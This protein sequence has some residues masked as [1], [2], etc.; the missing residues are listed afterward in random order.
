MLDKTAKASTTE[1]EDGKWKELHMTFLS[2]NGMRWG[3][4][5][6]LP[7]M[8]DSAWWPVLTSRE[9]ESPGIRSA[10]VS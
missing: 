8:T 10:C 7:S 4:L 6:A 5:R 9:K 1:D 2:Q 3:A